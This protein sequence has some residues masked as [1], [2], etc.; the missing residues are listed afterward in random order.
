MTFEESIEDINKELCKRRGK[1]T[2]TALA[3]MDFEDVAQIIRFHIFKKWALY[4]QTKPLA[5]WV[6]TVISS[7][8]KNLLRNNYS[9]YSRPCLHCAAAEGESDCRIYQKQCSDCPL[10]KKWEMKKKSAHDIKLPVSLSNHEQE[11]F[12]KPCQSID[13]DRSTAN[14]HKLMKTKLKPVEWRVYTYLYI[15]FKT[16][17][18]VAK[19]MGYKTSENRRPAGYKQIQNIKNAILKKVNEFKDEIEIV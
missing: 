12:E 2:L 1:W 19:L 13:W 11:V 7:Q 16:E 6:N 18:E 17:T 14:L 5:P 3:W 8:I 15:Q 9:N 10:Y 4:D